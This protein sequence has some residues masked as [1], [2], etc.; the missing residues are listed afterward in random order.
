MRVPTGQSKGYGFVRFGNE[1]EYKD[2]L[3]TMNG[4][5]GLGS[6][7]IKVSPAIPRKETTEYSTGHQPHA[8]HGSTPVDYSYYSHYDPHASYWGNATGWENYGAMNDAYYGAGAQHYDAH[9]HGYQQN[10]TAGQSAANSEDDVYDEYALV[11]KIFLLVCITIFFSLKFREKQLCIVM[12]FV[13][14][15]NIW[16]VCRILLV[17]VLSY[18]NKR[19][20]L[21]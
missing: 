8:V 21:S 14:I 18:R 19:E 10:G 5:R 4:Y 2:A 6:R 12:P 20:Q 7:P 15:D 1:D 11:G 16:K 9:A 17:L 13:V 3:I